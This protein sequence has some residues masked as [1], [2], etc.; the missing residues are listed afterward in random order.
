MPQLVQSVLLSTRPQLIDLNRE[1]TNFKLTFQCAAKNPQQEYE[2]IVITQEELDAADLNTLDYKKI[3]GTIGGKII[4]NENTSKN[5]FLVARQPEDSSSPLEIQITIDIEEIS[6]VNT[7]PPL[8]SQT[9]QVAPTP[10]PQT[11]ILSSLR[12]NLIQNRWFWIGLL[13]LIACGIFLYFYYERSTT[14]KIM[15]LPSDHLVESKILPADPVVVTDPPIETNIPERIPKKL[16]K[17]QFHQKLAEI[18]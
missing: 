10:L 11:S 1:F 15:P 2:I 17:H 18:A 16:Q 5:Y 9:V 12:T 14:P 13:L 7:P 6:S 3:K 8:P 4:A